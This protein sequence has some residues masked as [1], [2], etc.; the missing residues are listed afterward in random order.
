MRLSSVKNKKFTHVS[1]DS[2]AS[3]FVCEYNYSSLSHTHFASSSMTGLMTSVQ[4][5]LSLTIRKCNTFFPQHE[6]L[7]LTFFLITRLTP[8]VMQLQL[9]FSICNHAH[10]YISFSYH[11]L[12]SFIWFVTQVGVYSATLWAQVS[13]RVTESNFHWVMENVYLSLLIRHFIQV[14]PSYFLSSTNCSYYYHYNFRVPVISPTYK[15]T[16]KKFE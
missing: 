13:I 4:P 12:Q 16:R 9:F 7:P 3:H 5:Y 8:H 10:R 2:G 15:H 6:L 14:F 1:Y 11:F